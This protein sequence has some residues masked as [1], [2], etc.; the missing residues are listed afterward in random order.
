MVVLGDDTQV[1]GR[2][3]QVRRGE[4][5]VI[6]D[7]AGR[8]RTFPWAYVRRVVFAPQSGPAAAPLPL[9]SGPVAGSGAEPLG[10]DSSRARLANSLLI[11]GIVGLSF[12]YV[13]AA[14]GGAAGLGVGASQQEGHGT[15]CFKS[16][17]YAFIPFA[18]PLTAASKY[19]RHTV[20]GDNGFVRCGGAAAGVTAFGVL[21]TLVQ[22]G[23]AGVLIGGLVLGSS[24]P[25]P[26]RTGSWVLR[27]GVAGAPAGLTASFTW[28]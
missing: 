10:P 24:E 3:L 12:G 25:A 15:S 6:R 20:M 28:L 16:A 13:M 17:A 27:P 7:T 2:V 22:V 1:H 9:P 23:S 26:A 11:G 21:D 18:G 14:I 8:E 4:L 5:V 19:P